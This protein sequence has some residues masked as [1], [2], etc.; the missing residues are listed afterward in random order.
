MALCF[1]DNIHKRKGGASDDTGLRLFILFRSGTLR[2]RIAIA[3]QHIAVTGEQFAL[4]S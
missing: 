2:L 1:K 4:H 3:E